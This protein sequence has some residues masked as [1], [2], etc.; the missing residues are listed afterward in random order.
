MA[1]L[2]ELATHKLPDVEALID[3][4]QAMRAW[5]LTATDCSCQTLDVCGL[6]APGAQ[7]P[8]APGADFALGLTH[9]AK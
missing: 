5:L 6:F 9:V 3:R 8:A 4:A 7:P 2:R 1:A